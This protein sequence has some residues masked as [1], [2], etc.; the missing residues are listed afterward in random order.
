MLKEVDL[1]GERDKVQI[2]IER[3]RTFEPQEGYYLAFSG[4]KDSCVLKH[5]A[6]QAGVKYDSHYAVTTIDPPDLIYF[7]REHH[8]DVKFRRKDE[9]LL[10]KMVRKGYPTRK[11]RWCCEYLKEKAG[12]GRIVLTGIRWDESARRKKRKM[13]E[14]CQTDPTK[15]FL[16]PIID[17]THDDIWEYIKLYDLP[18]CKLYDMGFKR[19]GCLFCPMANQK[20]RDLEAQMY[21]RYVEVFRIFF[22]RLYDTLMSRGNEQMRF[23]KDGDALFNWWMY[24]L[25]KDYS[26]SEDTGQMSLFDCN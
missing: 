23:F 9:P 2:A 25:N 19:L 21:P 3:L 6:D 1:F 14:G 20:M 22:N 12:T 18:Y 15:K 4:G 8:K 16:H 13:V 17:F 26:S 7:I 10:H 5:L 24:N 11:V